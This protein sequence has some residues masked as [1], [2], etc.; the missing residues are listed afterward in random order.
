MITINNTGTNSDRF[1]IQHNHFDLQM[2]NPIDA[3]ATE[4]Q[5]FKNLAGIRGFYKQR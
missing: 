5:L 1:T 4:N 3:D 2:S